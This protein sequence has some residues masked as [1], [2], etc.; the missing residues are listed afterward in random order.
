ML[1]K[2]DKKKMA[3][4]EDLKDTNYVKNVNY[5]MFCIYGSL[6]FLIVIFTFVWNSF[7]GD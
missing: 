4:T 3:E 5:S 2:N 7:Y 6:Y 1:S